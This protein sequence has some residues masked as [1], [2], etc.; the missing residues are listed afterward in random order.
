MIDCS[1]KDN[2]SEKL[3]LLISK[4]DD[5][6]SSLIINPNKNSEDYIHENNSITVDS[7]IKD[8]NDTLNKTLTFKDDLL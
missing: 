4:D 8:K 1:I 6:K 5:L 7:D 3:D 2:S